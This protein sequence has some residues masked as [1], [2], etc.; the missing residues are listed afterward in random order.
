VHIGSQARLI[1]FA[2]RGLEGSRPLEVQL[3]RRV[4]PQDVTFTL[5][6][7]YTNLG[8]GELQ[9][10]FSGGVL[11]QAEGGELRLIAPSG[12]EIIRF[13]RRGPFQLSGNGE[14]LATCGPSEV[15]FTKLGD[16]GAPSGQTFTVATESAAYAV[17]FL[18]EQA[19]ILERQ[20]V[21]FVPL[22]G[23]SAGEALPVHSGKQG[24]FTSAELVPLGPGRV[25]VAVGRLEVKRP[26]ARQGGQL[27]PGLATAYADVF[28]IPDGLP[29]DS[30]STTIEL[31]RWNFDM[32][33]VRFVGQRPRMLVVTSE[34]VMLS[35]EVQLQ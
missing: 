6:G 23:G 2:A 10:S 17:R 26:P 14:W 21:S 18:G 30:C 13:E 27:V 29:L 34:V 35:P 7:T 25:G 16:D 15:R 32:P 19:V 28:V 24:S 1:A 4:Q 31:H 20:K 9:S 22:S 3:F 12:A 5:T 11:A 33:R 8:V